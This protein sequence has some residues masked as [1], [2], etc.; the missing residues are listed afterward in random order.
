[1]VAVEPEALT[2]SPTARSVELADWVALTVAELDVVT[3]SF[4]V[5]GVAGFFFLLVLFAF[6]DPPRFPRDSV[7]PEM[8]TDVPLTAVTLPD[9]MDRLASCLRKLLAPEPPPGTLGRVPLPPPSKPPPPPPVLPR[10]PKPP[11]PPGALPGAP[12]AMRF[13]A[14]V[15]VPLEDGVVT[16]MVRAATV[17]LD[18]FDAVPVAEMQSPTARELTPSVTVFENWVVVVQPTVVCPVL[19]FCTSMLVPLSEATLPDAPVGRFGVDAAPAGAATAAAATSA[20]TPPPMR[21]AQRFRF[22]RRL[23]G[24]CI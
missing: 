7:V 9:T 8:L 14:A 22:G 10:K 19:A 20:V 1:M 5:L 15:H 24:V 11:A 21:W 12:P 17:V 3:V 18:F 4:S 2:Q 23:V 16:V 6:F 13:P